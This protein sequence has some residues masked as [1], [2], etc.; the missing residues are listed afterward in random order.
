ML[1]K[2]SGLRIN[3]GLA[4]SALFL[5]GLAACGGGTTSTT[6]AGTKEGISLGGNVALTGAGAS[7]P[8]PL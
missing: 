2:I 1:H 3:L 6:G 7:F 5:T 4:T 8:A